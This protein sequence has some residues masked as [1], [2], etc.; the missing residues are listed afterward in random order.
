MDLRAGVNRMDSTRTLILEF[1]DTHVASHIRELHI[2]ILRCRPETPEHTIRARLSE[3]AGHGLLSRLG[4]GF[5]DVYAEDED[6]TSV[7]SYPNRCPLWGDSRYR[8]NCDGRLF[9]NLVLRYRAKKVGDPIDRTER[10]AHRAE[11]GYIQTSD[12]CAV[13]ATTGGKP[14]NWK[15]TKVDVWAGEMEDRPG[16]LAEKLEAVRKAGAN[17]QFVIARR[18]KPGKSVVFLAP[19]KG[20]SQ[21]RAARQVGLA[22]ATSLYSLRLEGPD[23]RGLGGLITRALAE[24][25][26]NLRGLS[27]AALGRSHVTYFAFECAEDARRAGPVLKKA[28][29]NT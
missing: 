14:M 12:R 25:G 4:D 29:K 24:A 22:K 21:V 28:L 8:G 27:A 1:V 16:A 3:A 19:L 9:K 18:D 20:A 2:E 13:R 15:M 17:L 7:V 6:M 10:L 11:P 5:Y 26:I 23:R